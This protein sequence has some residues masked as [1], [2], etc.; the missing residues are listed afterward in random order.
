M[1]QYDT[2]E[3]ARIL[4]GGMGLGLQANRMDAEQERR[5]AMLEIAQQRASAQQAQADAKLALDRDKLGFQRDR[6]GFDQEKAGWLNDYRNAGLD[7]RQQAI[8][9]NQQRASDRLAF[10][11]EK[12]EAGR[13]DMA[14]AAQALGLIG[15]P[16]QQSNPFGFDQPQP[17]AS[18]ALQGEPGTQYQGLLS[19]PD[20]QAMPQQ[21]QMQLIRDANKQR[22]L[23]RTQ[24]E[25]S[26]KLLA[27]AQSAREKGQNKLADALE[28]QAT[29]G[30]NPGVAAR[31]LDEFDVDQRVQEMRDSGLYSP[32]HLAGMERIM[33]AT[34]KPPTNTAAAGVMAAPKAPSLSNDRVYEAMQNEAAMAREQL[35]TFMDG[36][37]VYQLAEMPELQAQKAALEQR[38]VQ[39]VE[40]ANAYL[41]KTQAPVPQSP[42]M[43]M[44]QVSP[45]MPPAQ[46]PAQQMPTV[47]R[48]PEAMRL[49]LPRIIAAFRAKH[50]RDPVAG[51]D[52]AAFE[53]I[54]QEIEKLE[55]TNGR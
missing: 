25:R 50:G 42:Q 1:G 51:V 31:I 15:A 5:A 29:S 17:P 35:R 14:G 46:T 10:D 20:F 44:G 16:A 21:M 8:D 55:A 26:K 4:L 23:T 52:D 40:S 38:Y 13:G 19:R 41:R 54:G 43:P 32:D 48:S 33:R 47:D 11:R 7:L 12:F 36:V 49:R 39:A 45:A 27:A 34:G 9:L 6:F 28:A 22:M 18:I 24:E 53:Q 30:I 3:L 2:G 37:N